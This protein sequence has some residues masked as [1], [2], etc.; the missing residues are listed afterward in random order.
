MTAWVNAYQAILL[1]GAW[2]TAADWAAMAIWLALGALL[3][4]VLLGRSRDQ[5][6]DWL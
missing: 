1:Q 4:N 5:L 3:L 2:P 6:T